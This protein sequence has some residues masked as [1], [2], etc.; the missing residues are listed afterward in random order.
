MITVLA[1]NLYKAASKAKKQADKVPSLPV[2]SCLL[3]AARGDKLTV[4]PFAWEERE[5]KAESVP[6]R[7]EGEFATCV[8]ARAFVD[9]LRASQEKPDKHAI[10]RGVTDQIRLELDAAI[11]ILTVTGSNFRAQFKCI[12]AAVFPHISA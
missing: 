8:P 4:Y 9:W 5:K 1:T 11:Q 6:A 12:D 10:G 2:A 7:I 3:I